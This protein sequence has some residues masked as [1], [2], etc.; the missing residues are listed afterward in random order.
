V[1]LTV[2][3]GANHLWDLPQVNC[4][5]RVLLGRGVAGLFLVCLSCLARFCVGFSFRVGCVLGVFLF[6]GLEKSLRL[7]ETL[8]VWLV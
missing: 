6:Q 7:S 5:T 1:L 3:T 4:W 8:V 2:L